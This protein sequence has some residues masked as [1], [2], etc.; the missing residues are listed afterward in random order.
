[1]MLDPNSPDRCAW[2]SAPTTEV[3]VPYSLPRVI[4]L[5]TFVRTDRSRGQFGTCISVMQPCCDL[6]SPAQARNNP[7]HTMTNAISSTGV[8]DLK[9]VT[10]PHVRSH[11]PALFSARTGAR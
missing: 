7:R 10:H 11:L 4:R 5:M 9:N 1:M 6:T 3:A 8:D 2:L